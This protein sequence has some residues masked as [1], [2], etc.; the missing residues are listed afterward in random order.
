MRNKDIRGSVCYDWRDRIELV[1]DNAGRWHLCRIVHMDLV[2]IEDVT[3]KLDELNQE[4]VSVAWQYGQIDNHIKAMRARENFLGCLRELE[5]EAFWQ[6]ER[7]NF[8][9]AAEY[10]RLVKKYESVA[11][12]VWTRE[13]YEGL[14][15]MQSVLARLEP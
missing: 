6:K 15:I 10:Q 5:A 2:P 1:I 14:E 11:D 12:A 7:R 4:R 13:W 3:D 8:G 9:N